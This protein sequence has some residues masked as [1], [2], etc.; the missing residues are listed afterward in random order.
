MKIR[1][2]IALTIV[3]VVAGSSLNFNRAESAAEY[4]S[5][6]RMATFEEAYQQSKAVFLGEVVEEE[7]EGDT[8]VFDFK[9]EKYWKGANQ[10][11]LK[12]SVYETARYQA[13]FKKGGSYLVYAFEDTEG[14]LRV[15]RCSRSGDAENAKEDLQKL[16]KGKIPR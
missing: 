13:W 12:I 4:S 14:N 11:N 15:G 9:V 6:C 10:K 7:K 3:A 2:L 5:K 8:R 1:L 16:G